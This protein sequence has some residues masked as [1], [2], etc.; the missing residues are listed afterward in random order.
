MTKYGHGVK[1][2]LDLLPYKPTVKI[3]DSVLAIRILTL[4]ASLANEVIE[5]TEDFF[6][7]K[8]MINFDAHVGE[9]LCQIR[10]CLLLE[11]EQE[12]TREY[13]DKQIYIDLV[14]HLK[15]NILRIEMLIEHF[16][17]ERNRKNFI[18]DTVE[19][20]LEKNK[21]NIILPEPLHFLNVSHFLYKLKMFN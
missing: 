18:W 3:Y 20:L 9:N 13:E 1:Y 6:L 11:L 15:D 4:L 12:F 17:K 19:G 21:L 7:T 14:L 8:N 10:A 5:S 16:K 2:I